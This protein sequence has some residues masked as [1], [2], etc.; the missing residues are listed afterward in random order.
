MV[1][2]CCCTP[3]LPAGVVDVRFSDAVAAGP[4]AVRAQ[5]RPRDDRRLDSHRARGT[6][7]DW[8]L[9]LRAALA[10]PQAR[11]TRF[12]ACTVSVPALILCHGLL[13]ADML[14]QIHD[15]IDE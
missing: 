9:L 4:G 10:P 11:A 3:S 15:P 8:P 5:A 12:R 2:L 1:A 14:P 6:C 13:C 7:T